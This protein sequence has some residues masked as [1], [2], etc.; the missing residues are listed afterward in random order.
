METIVFRSS[1]SETGWNFFMVYVGD[2]LILSQNFMEL[3]SI[4]E[5]LK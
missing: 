4:V 5:D 3:N 2:I 1:S